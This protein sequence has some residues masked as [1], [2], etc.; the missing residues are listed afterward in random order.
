LRSRE[1]LNLAYLFDP[2]PGP[3]APHDLPLHLALM[4]LLAV[5]LGT[6]VY[7]TF[8]ARS[9][10]SS[11]W[12]R[13][14][15]IPLSLALLVLMEARLL[16]IPHL[17]MPILFYAIAS[18]ALAGWAAHLLGESHR[19]G[20]LRR[21]LA[22]LTFSSREEAASTQGRATLVLLAGHLTGLL[23]LSVHLGR[24][25]LWMLGL[26]LLLLSP[27]L[28]PSV[29]PRRWSI[30]LEA[31][32][33]L[34]CAYLAAVVRQA[35]AKVL[36]EPLPL[37]D[38]FTYPEPLSALFNIEAILVASVVYVLLCQ[39]YLLLLRRR[40]AHKHLAYVGA[41]L[42]LAVFLWAGVVYFK[43]RTHG[44]TA[45]D[46]YA[47]AQMAVDIAEH[48][49]PTHE[50]PLF[51]RI[52][53]LGISWWPAVHYGY[54]VRMPP[55]KADGHTATDWPPG[56][57]VILSLGYL[58]L[59]EQGLY[60]VNPLMGLL[61]LLALFALVWELLR[62]APREQRLLGGAVSAFCLATSYEQ[63]DRLVVPMADAAAQLF[64]I[65]TL[66]LLLRGVQKR[67]RAHALVAGLCFGAAYA[68][69]H[70][71]LA[72]GLCAL[73]ALLSL[74][75][76]GNTARRR[77]EFVGLFG[78][79]ALLVAIP[80][81]LYHQLV[82]GHF[83]TPEST[84]L[85]LFSISHVAVTARL[86]WARAMSRNELG[87]LSPLLVYGGYRMYVARRGQFLVLLSAVLAVLAVHLPYAALRFRDL[88]SLLPIAL[89]WVG[90]GVADLWNRIPIGRGVQSYRRHTGGVLILLALV[91]LPVLR[92]WHILPRPWGVYRGS[93]GYLTVEERN[94][95]DALANHTT[96]QCV[97][98]SSLNGG[99]IDLYA[100][101]QAFR[102]AFWSADEFDVFLQEMFLD[103]TNVYILD[104]GEALHANLAHARAHYRVTS[105]A[106]LT[107]PLFGDPER[108]SSVLYQIR[109]PVGVQE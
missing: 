48:G 6:S 59:G 97:V 27:Q 21:Q 100:R 40:R 66:L 24:S 29:R 75:R 81:L 22:V 42:V 16:A 72:I 7:G 55:L 47:Y 23:V 68:I 9:P 49:E 20:F 96:N 77:M 65:L 46:P 8:F 3:L 87:Y 84:E 74:G 28:L 45:N 102:P 17:S 73:V 85:D 86:M 64:T 5:G 13:V 79:A 67:Y 58:L 15:L 12:V 32:S 18:W 61:C 98:G 107:V 11:R 26:F 99:P 103:G 78:L 10:S 76:Q 36:S 95:F 4:M 56:W 43:H 60:L 34:W 19:S 71:Q 33:P 83:L 30:H 39:G 62:D 91:L 51:R 54:Q 44:V 1:L 57:P 14:G 109:P 53:E 31:L 35:C 70:T 101:R 2:R 88:L 82:F 93:F 37:C 105:I 92:T 63:I 89:A 94:G 90:Y 25:Y 106:E 69:R 104:D 52:S 50:F 41:A 38:G 108:I 80:D